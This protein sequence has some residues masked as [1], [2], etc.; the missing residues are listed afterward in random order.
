MYA[1]FGSQVLGAAA[2]SLAGLFLMVVGFWIVDLLTPGKLGEL[3]WT[4][5]NRNA[6]LLLASNMFGVG[7]I[8]V[9]AIWA[10]E[11]DL[12]QGLVST[13]VFGLV[14]LVVMALS[15][16]VLDLLTPGKLGVLVTSEEMHP[17]VW[18]N[19]AVH[20]ALGAVIAMALS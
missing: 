6:A 12:V 14:G 19:A 9:G 1:Q 20:I 8:A 15:F 4:H 18:V 2:Y 7:I 13:A 10:S 16:L 3:I 5:R 17:A 11:G